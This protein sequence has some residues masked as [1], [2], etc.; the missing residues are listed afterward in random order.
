MTPLVFFLTMTIGGAYTYAIVIYVFCFIPLIDVILK[1]QPPTATIHEIKIKK[2]KKIIHS[3]KTLMISHFSMCIY[4]FL[5]PFVFLYSAAKYTH[6]NV[7][8][9]I[10]VGMVS[11][12]AGYI[13]L[14]CAILHELMHLSNKIFISYTT[15]FASLFGFGTFP[16]EH[17][18]CHHNLQKTCTYG[19]PTS[20]R[21]GES[22][23]AYI[24]RAYFTMFRSAF[25]F[26]K[27]RLARRS[28]SPWRF[29]NTAISSA[30]LWLLMMGAVF[31]LLGLK[32]L[33]FYLLCCASGVSCYLIL[34]YTTHYGLTRTVQADGTIEPYTHL[35]AWNCNF[36][37]LNIASVE[38]THHSDHHIR[39]LAP[40]YDLEDIE[41]SPSLPVGWFNLFPI[42]LIPPLWRRM[43]DPRVLEVRT[44]ISGDP[45]L[46]VADPS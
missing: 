17:I 13:V 23:Y 34:L 9:L 39:P 46:R 1:K 22:V 15:F 28:L 41:G 33:I 7:T 21:L 30:L 36:T 44:R 43:M 27:E 20:A 24:A 31:A 11:A 18:H 38:T 35:H 19:D 16:L 3:V 8:I 25:Q 4:I 32:G 12:T 37:L 10:A 26:E 40:Y 6:G 5:I 45:V 14:A 2:A 29:S 42:I